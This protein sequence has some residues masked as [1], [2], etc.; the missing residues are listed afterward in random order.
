MLQLKYLLL[1][2]VLISKFTFSQQIELTHLNGPNG[3]F[4]G[5]VAINS[6]GDIFAGVY[7]GWTDYSGLYKST[8]NGSSWQKIESQFDDFEVYAIYINKE[9]HIW[10][11]T[12]FQDRI[13]RS[14]DN[15]NTWENKRN[16][17]STGECWAFG[18]S[19]DGVLFAG[20]GQYWNISR[21]TDNG[22][23]WE[24]LN[25]IR[26]LV[27]KTSKDNVIYAGAQDGL[28]ATS[29]NGDTWALSDSL[30]DVA[31]PSIAIDDSGSIY[32]GT[33]YY[34]E[35]KGIFKSSDNGAT[36]NYIGLKGKIVLSLA[37]DSKG[38][39]FAGTKSNGVYKTTDSGN[40]WTNYNEGLY[41]KDAFRM[42]IN[43]SDHIFI[44]AE[45]EGVFRSLDGGKT[46][47][48][49]GLPLSIVNN[50]VCSGD[51]VIFTSTKSG[52]QKYNRITKRWTNLGLHE[53]EA[54]D[55]T[56]SGD[57]YAAT[58]RNGL[59]KST[60]FG[61][62]WFETTLMD[63]DLFSVYNVLAINND[64][65][66]VA[67]NNFL[68]YS[69][70]AG[71]NWS[72]SNIVTSSS[73]RLLFYY[74]N[75]I[76]VVGFTSE[77]D[78]LYYSTNYGNNF[79]EL[80]SFENTSFYREGIAMYDNYQVITYNDSRSILISKDN[81]LT[82]NESLTTNE[83]KNYRNAFFR[84]NGH[85]LV[86]D[87]Y[88][89]FY[90][91]DFGNSFVTIDDQLKPKNY[92]KDIEEDENGQL[93]FSTEIEGLF[94]VDIITSIDEEAPNLN[95][96]TLS[97]NYPNPFNPTTTI[98]YNIPVVALSV[99]EGLHVSLKIYDLLGREVAILVNEQQ[100]PGNYKVEW[101]ADNYS[102]GIYFYKLTAG[103]FTQTRK[104][105][106]LR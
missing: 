4:V 48:Q 47:K 74:N 44:G 95:E 96:F 2:L 35:G 54:I 1:L 64:T 32:C 13:Y 40:T 83:N 42:K 77:Q 84:S 106:L 29:D 51:S 71:L 61:E 50:S 58:F 57:L 98:Q 7:S 53:V 69:Y 81:G 27:F 23:T 60:D 52:V 38:T 20:D 56:P 37:F 11:G 97:Q 12:N 21:S 6:K 62:T 93:F 55:I 104:M 43:S 65:I 25:Q 34:T 18:E 46:F 105:I 26:P 41:R 30:K 39:L 76:Y 79:I 45:E 63:N 28:Y 75:K 19:L 3:G 17:Y 102:S 68:R 87:L 92:I 94:E 10:V 9:D 5:D 90:S 8:D 86:N 85:L 49:V 99:V 82:W 31:V 100:K 66:F 91:I 22:D 72:I 80:L 78:V 59:L 33:G 16:G 89:L 15:G 36:W 14:T 101:N 103:K 70:D 73:N 67:T 88:D 24:K